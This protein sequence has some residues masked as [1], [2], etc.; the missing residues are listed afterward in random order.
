MAHRASRQPVRASR[1]VVGTALLGLVPLLAGADPVSAPS[2]ARVARALG[3]LPVRFERNDGQTDPRVRFLSRGPGY[4]LFLATSEVVLSLD[5]TPVPGRDPLARRVLPREAPREASVLRMR[6]ADARPRPEVEGIDPLLARS[7]YFVGSDPKRWRADVP[8]FGRVAYRGLWKGIDLTFYGTAEGR[9]EWDFTV[10]PGAD[11]KEIRL[12][13]EGARSVLVD[14]E[15][16]LVIRT[17]AGEVVQQRPHLYQDVGGVRT[18]RSGSWVLRGKRRAGFRVDGYDR[19]APL[20]I[21][22][23]LVYSTYL[24]GSRDEAALAVAPTPRATPS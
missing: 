15:G 5:K 11:P 7:H 20:V 2:P 3:R 19:T 9:L 17:E 14:G 12:A 18:V 8:Q 24:G 1:V 13:F 22:P 23:V 16:N 4:G 6:F 10:S 21:D